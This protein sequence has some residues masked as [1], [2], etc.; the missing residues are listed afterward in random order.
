MA[1]NKTSRLEKLEQRANPDG[2]RVYAMRDSQGLFWVNDQAYTEK[3]FNARYGGQE[4]IV[5]RV[6]FD[7]SKV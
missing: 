6:G 5:K 1:R 7:I 4:I 2:G 3:E